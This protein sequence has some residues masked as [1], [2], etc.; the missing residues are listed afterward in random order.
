MASPLAQ[1]NPR[2]ANLV[3]GP[4]RYGTRSAS[5]RQDSFRLNEDEETSLIRDLRDGSIG[6]LAATGNVL[7]LPGSSVRD[8]LAGRNPVDQ[9]APWNWTSSNDRTTGKQLLQDYGLAGGRDTWGKA[10]A[11]FG[12]EVAFDPLTYLTGGASALGKVGKAAKGTGILDDLGRVA[13]RKAGKASGSIGPRQAR[14]STTLD[15]FV[16]HGSD[17]VSRKAAKLRDEMLAQG[18]DPSKPIGGSVGVGIPFMDPS[19]VVGQGAKSEAVAKAVDYAADKARRLPL[20]DP[21]ARLFNAQLG[22]TKGKWGQAIAKR[23]FREQEKSASG[24]RELGAMHANMLKDAGFDKEGFSDLIRDLAEGVIKPEQLP[25]DARDVLTRTAAWIGEE[26]RSDLARAAD[27]G[28][29][30]HQLDDTQIQ[31][32]ARFL[33][34]DSKHYGRRDNRLMAAFSPSQIARIDEFRD[35]AG[36]TRDIKLLAKDDGLN[37]L[38][39]D[40]ADKPG[41]LKEITNYIKTNFG[42]KF[43]DEYRVTDETGRLGGETGL[44]TV[45]GRHAALAKRLAGMSEETRRKGIFDNHVI[46]DHVARRMSF[47]NAEAATV[48]LRDAL[49][50]PTILEDSVGNLARDSDRIEVGELI[51]KVGLNF[52]DDT[53]GFGKQLADALG[54]GGKP[55]GDIKKMTISKENAD[56]LVKVMETIRTPEAM[57]EILD[58][59]D[60]ATNLGKGL[61]TSA[62]P[63]FHVRNFVSGQ[64]HNSLLNMTDKHSLKTA[65]ALQRGGKTN[66]LKDIDKLREMARERGY[67]VDGLGPQGGASGGP[68]GGG[69]SPKPGGDLEKPAWHGTPH[70]FAAERLIRLPDGRQEYVVG[71]PGKLPDVPDG[72]ELIK[73]Y[74]KGRHRSEKAR[75]GEGNAAFGEGHYVADRRE[76][77]QKYKD[78]LTAGNRIVR[79]D[80]EEYFKPGRIVDSYGGKDEV[81]SFNW[82]DDGTWSVDVRHVGEG[83]TGAGRVRRHS[84][85][86]G[87]REFR[88]AIGRDPNK[89]GKLQKLDLKPDEDDYLLWDKPM[90]EQ[91]ERVRKSLGIEDPPPLPASFRPIQAEIE[92]VLKQAR[93]LREKKNSIPTHE[94]RVD[95][96]LWRAYD[97]EQRQLSKK[98]LELKSKAGQMGVDVDVHATQK[99]AKYGRTATGIAKINEDHARGLLREANQLQKDIN[100]IQWDLKTIDPNYP[101]NKGKVLELGVGLRQK[102][103]MLSELTGEIEKLGGKV[104]Q[105]GNRLS[106][107]VSE[108]GMT[109]GEYYQK[110]VK[111]AQEG[112]LEDVDMGELGSASVNISP[113]EA[114]S[115]AS[116]KLLDKGVRG[117]KFLDRASRSKGEGTYNYVV[118]DGNDIE[119]EDAF[120]PAGGGDLQSVS[121]AASKSEGGPAVNVV[122]RIPKQQSQRLQGLGVSSSDP[123]KWT[124]EDIGIVTDPI[125]FASLS[126]NHAKAGAIF[127]KL[128]KEGGLEPEDAIILRTVY[129]QTN[130]QYLPDYVRA[131]RVLQNRRGRRYSS[132][133]GLMSRDWFGDGSSRRMVQ[134]KSAKKGGVANEGTQ[135]LL[136]EMAHT[137]WYNAIEKGGDAHRNLVREF[138]ELSQESGTM[139]FYNEFRDTGASPNVALHTSGAGSGSGSDPSVEQFA[140]F[141]ATSV[142]RRRV[143]AGAMGKVISEAMN[144]LRT[145]LNNLKG[146]KGLDTKVR[147]RLDQIIDELGGFK[148]PFD[149]AKAVKNK[150]PIPPLDPPKSPPGGGTAGGGG[151]GGGPPV[152]PVKNPYPTPPPEPHKPWTEEA[153]A[154]MLGELLY[155]HNVIGKFDANATDVVGQGAQAVASGSLE[156]MLHGILRP[157]EKN[158]SA[159]RAGAKFVGY[160]YGATLN[161]RKATA[162]GVRGATESTFGPLAAGEEVGH[163]VEGLN[164]ITPFLNLVKKGVDPAEAA[165]RVGVAQI[166][167]GNKNYTSFEQKVMQRMFP[168]YKFTKGIAPQVVKELMER[169]G[170]R[171]AQTVRAQR[172]A[173]DSG[174]IAPDYVRE[175]AS[176]PLGNSL[177][178]VPEGTDR[179]LTGLGLMHEDP[180]SFGTSIQGSLLETASRLNP[181]LKGPA[182]IATNQSFFQKGVDGGR[183][184]DDLDPLVGRLISN[185]SGR[186]DPVRLPKIAEAALANSPISKVLSTAR[187]LT[188]PRKSIEGTRIPGP[189]AL[190]NTMTG[191]RITDVSPGSKDAM[192]RELLQ[193]AEKDL[194]AKTFERVYF[195]D[196]D[197]A[198]MT[199]SQQLIAKQMEAL[200]NKQARDAKARKKAMER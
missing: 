21:L 149:S 29:R 181:F 183:N 140:E 115:I 124:S 129:A 93:D 161:P 61:W 22:D 150:N 87:D 8:L 142:L 91:S 2:L 47:K 51:H 74:P 134:L 121:P 112:S 24:P 189:A 48:A 11:G 9:W 33:T 159:R 95:P 3:E 158:F 28:M 179:Y 94:G 187:T 111:E 73:D 81:V 128:V 162:R 199:P 6:A 99:T 92:S 176:I 42:N 105:D 127:D 148:G 139:K 4:V 184:L 40:K 147:Q 82:N 169:P 38:I 44:E 1:I 60:S 173:Q 76:L 164:R 62:W 104:V 200:S 72:A 182:E 188:D 193:R 174:D 39:N 145:L 101:H 107:K 152:P 132:A 89:G 16:S 163:F 41:G 37:K 85:S 135:T 64:V 153:A 79:S 46:Q 138:K 77:A 130:A 25:A 114:A 19:F 56:D 53:G 146:V 75:T 88:K 23:V 151:A 57:N 59:I 185:I 165:R 170:G 96:D 157:G 186:E 156:D 12:A 66:G 197:L 52:G 27:L 34:R 103:K 69:P 50:E 68:S 20:V 55:L 67:D 190:L 119:I 102:T 7:D 78:M 13:A 123:L 125:K 32:V 120:K 191:L 116:R 110:L 122:P 109:G 83:G 97:E 198:K 194:G 144:W 143:P 117:N 14:V 26:S 195:K 15:D 106:L 192:V 63:A 31:S 86:P 196:E 160:G 98:I 133:A 180:F 154:K 54:A 178:K 65:W 70:E 58:F 168:F 167:Y 43:S 10:I 17:E 84:T 166:M 5:R 175:S 126:E 136:H 113:Q 18:L 137:V 90:S 171:L 49:A 45:S 118:F 108:S 155:A 71:E 172:I 131:R 35:V 30:I 80:L 36:G 177:G 141:F 100:Q